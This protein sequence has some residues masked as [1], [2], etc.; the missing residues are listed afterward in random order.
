[1][2]LPS[3]P[4]P[5]I[6]TSNTAPPAAILVHYTAE[7]HWERQALKRVGDWLGAAGLRRGKQKY[8]IFGHFENWEQDGN[9]MSYTSLVILLLKLFETPKVTN[10]DFSIPLRFSCTGQVRALVNRVTVRYP[11][12]STRDHVTITAIINY[13]YRLVPNK[14]LPAELTQLTS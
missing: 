6:H 3:T 4:A 14:R 13:I 8:C 5:T 1:M 10:Q 7:E 12:W 11:W 2:E 9:S